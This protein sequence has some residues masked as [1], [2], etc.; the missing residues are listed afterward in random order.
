[1]RQGIRTKNELKWTGECTSVS[2]V[3]HVVVRTQLLDS[4][5][6]AYSAAESTAYNHVKEMIEGSLSSRSPPI[7]CTIEVY[8][9]TDPTE[10]AALKNSLNAARVLKHRV[11][12][13]TAG[14]CEF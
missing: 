6:A 14:F 5:K 8:D 4:S 11:T 9:P 7:A 2:C 3:V 13:C 1:M 10:V 12:S